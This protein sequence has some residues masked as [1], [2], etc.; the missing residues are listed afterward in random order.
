MSFTVELTRTEGVARV[1]LSNPGSRNAI[2][3]EGM[4]DLGDAIV[5]LS[6]DPEVRC[7]VIAGDG[8]AFCAGAELPVATYS[9]PGEAENRKMMAEANRTISALLDA[10]M[11]VVAEVKGPAVGIGAS[12]ALACDIVVAS[13]TGYFL[14]PFIGIGL[15][16][17]GG[18]TLTVAAS[19]GRARALRLAL[20]N[21][22][23][24]AQDALACGLIATVTE[25]ED[26]EDE[27]SRVAGVLA[28]GAATALRSTKAIINRHTLGGLPDV[29]EEE[30]RVQVGLL[31]GGEFAEGVRAFRERRRPS[32]TFPS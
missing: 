25:P 19:I 29:L 23:L 6:G 3:V 18:A 24:P 17:D 2:G 22:R 1:V 4:R 5:A 21:E 26:L 14:L 11:P 15:I 32:F 27:V 12:L 31:A 7:L 8:D 13:R 20:L 30:A 16:P 28:A 9:L 10:P